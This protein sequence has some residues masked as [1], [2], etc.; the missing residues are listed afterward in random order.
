MNSECIGQPVALQGR[1]PCRVVGTVNKGDLVTSS[2][3][4]GVATRLDPKDWVPGCV[5]GKSLEAYNSEEPGIIEVL[6]GRL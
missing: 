2:N 3:T 4:L 1:V 6:V 5:I